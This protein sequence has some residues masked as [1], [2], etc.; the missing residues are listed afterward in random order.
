MLVNEDIIV[1]GDRSDH[2]RYLVGLA[3]ASI[4]LAGTTVLCLRHQRE[5]MLAPVSPRRKYYILMHLFPFVVASSCWF[6]VAAPE[7]AVGTL[8]VQEILGGFGTT[9][10]WVDYYRPHGG[11]RNDGADLSTT[12]TSG[13]VREEPLVCPPLL[14]CSSSPPV[15]FPR[16][17]HCV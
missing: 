5:L 8:L 9:F 16:W 17:H 6:Q 3:V 12:G 10:L 7:L 13:T 14:L 11:S 2:A 1:H 15:C 4:L